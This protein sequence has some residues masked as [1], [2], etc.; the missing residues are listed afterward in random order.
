MAK[1]GQK[2]DAAEEGRAADSAKEEV[3]QP[4]E[5]EGRAADSLKVI[6][7]VRQAIA[8]DG[9]VI[10]PQVEDGGRLQGRKPIVKPVKGV[11]TRALAEALG[12]DYVKEIGPAP[13]DAPLGAMKEQ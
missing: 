9:V 10:R 13:D 1:K 7:E 4:A 5:A 3:A 8:F 12:P 2:T 11:I 6:V